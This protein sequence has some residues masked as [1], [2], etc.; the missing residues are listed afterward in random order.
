M[1]KVTLIILALAILTLLLG[2][3]CNQKEFNQQVL[4]Q[5]W[6]SI[7]DIPLP[8]AGYSGTTGHGLFYL[9]SR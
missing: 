6:D 2:G 3:C 8:D 4:T 1:K 7:K 9:K 5:A